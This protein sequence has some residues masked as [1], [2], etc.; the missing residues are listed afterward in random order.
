MYFILYKKN[1]NVPMTVNINNR[2]GLVLL[3]LINKKENKLTLVLIHLNIT[4]LG[5]VESI[6]VSTKES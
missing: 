3:L 6:R 5:G 4:K 2:L 1:W